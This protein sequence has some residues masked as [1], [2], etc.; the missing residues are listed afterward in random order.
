[1]S[2]GSRIRGLRAMARQGLLIGTRRAR[3]P[4]ER[5]RNAPVYMLFV[6]GYLAA[7][8]VFDPMRDF[9]SR[10]HVVDTDA[11]DYGPHERYGRVLERVLSKLENERFERPVILLGHSLGG[12]LCRDALAQVPHVPECVVTLATPHRGTRVARAVPGSLAAALRPDS[13]IVQRLMEAPIRSRAINVV[14]DE[15]GTVPRLAA[16]WPGSEEYVLEGVGH[17][18]IVF[19]ESCWHIVEGVL[20]DL[21]AASARDR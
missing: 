6:H 19:D 14:A 21:R 11:I 4:K 3:A 16:R 13:D 1:M 18:G 17:N 9:L 5:N 7:S 8:P 2:L 15:D 20:Q 12:L 10:R